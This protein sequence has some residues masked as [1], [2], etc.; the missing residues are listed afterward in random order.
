MIK[1]KD[2][3]YLACERLNVYALLMMSAGMMGAYT[4]NL[5]GGVFCN[6]QTANFVM[7]AVSFGNGDAGAGLYYL[8]PIAAY[9]LGAIVSEILPSPLKKLGFLRWDTYLIAFEMVMFVIIGFIPLSVPDHVVQVMINFIASMQYNTYRQMEGIP[10]ATT[11]CT[12]HVRQ[13]GIATAKFFRN[14]D[15]KAGR[16]GALH[17]LMLL[18]FFAGAVILSFLCSSLGEKA[19]WIALIPT[20]IVFAE[21]L[22]ADLWSEH[23]MLDRK[24]S[25]H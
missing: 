8:I 17:L 5:R 7:M 19:I 11:F 24:P 20:A 16:R 1:G 22:H 10:M 12:N 9:L 4:F 14:H 25:G 3:S 13:V 21:L 6:A 2:S 15:R 18:S 23:D